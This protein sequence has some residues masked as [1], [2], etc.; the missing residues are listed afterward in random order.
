M[1]HHISANP[2]ACGDYTVSPETLEGDLLYLRE[3]GYQS[4][5]LRDLL[6]YVDGEATLPEH[7]ILI[8]FDDGQESFLQYGLP[9]F[10]KYEMHAVLAIIGTCADA[11]TKTEDHNVNYSYFSWPALAELRQSPQVE[12]I[13]HSYDMHKLKPRRGCRILEG[14]NTQSYANAFCQD[15]SL[16]EGHFE[17]QLG[18]LPFAFAYPY[19]AYCKEAKN[20]LVERGYR[21]LFTCNP[22]VNTLHGNAEDLLSL[23]RFNRPNSAERHA[24]FQK[25]GI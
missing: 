14:E 23:G 4:V 1:Y 6:A 21:I 20:V 25:M 24:F 22:I 2:A 11:Y 13:A 19:G 16:L 9:L 18:E 10:E 7:P 8:T 12:L 17:E 5:S 15:L 3:H